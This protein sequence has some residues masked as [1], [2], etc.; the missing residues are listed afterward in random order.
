[1]KNKSKLVVGGIVAAVALVA[2]V[3][4]LFR[5]KKDVGSGT[6]EKKE[7]IQETKTA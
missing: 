3:A 5:S 2:A 1:M 7:E 4:W 6:V